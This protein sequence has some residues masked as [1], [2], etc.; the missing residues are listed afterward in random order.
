MYAGIDDINHLFSFSHLD[1]LHKKC[2]EK[3]GKQNLC[4]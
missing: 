2:K 3:S 4:F 1:Y